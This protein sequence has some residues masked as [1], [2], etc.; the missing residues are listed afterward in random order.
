MKKIYTLVLLAGMMLQSCSDFLDRTPSTSLPVEMAITNLK[1]LN[2]AVNGIPYILIGKRMSYDSDF[3]IFADMRGEDFSPKNNVNQSGNLARYQ[4]TKYDLESILLYGNFYQAIANVNKIFSVIDHVPYA[5]QEAAKFNDLKGQLYA[6]RALLHFDLARSFSQAP[7]VCSDIEAPNSGIVL[8][9]GVYD[10]HYIGTRATL[11][12]TYDQI[13]EDFTTA[14]PLLSK[15]AHNGYINYWAALALRSRAYLYYGKDAEALKDAKDVIASDLYKLYDIDNYISVW[16][17]EYTSESLFELSVTTIYNS[18]RNAL[19][20]YCDSEGYGEC[21]FVESAPLYAYL[22]SHPK[23]IRSKLIKIQEGQNPSTGKDYQNPGKFPAKYPGREGS[24]YINNPK[25][26]RLSEVYL[27][28]AEA[29]LKSRQG[30]PEDYINE[31]REKRIE[32]YEPVSSV[33]LDDI[34]SE[35]RYELFTE[36][37]LS[38]DMWRNKKSIKNSN[39]GVVDYNDYRTIFPL[40]QDEIDVSHG[41]LVQNP[42]Y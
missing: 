33:T 1:D 30:K 25:I 24:L 16:G 27:I 23:D 4:A 13:I 36:N 2:N 29:S 34:L 9:L 21:M 15:E 35:R 6:W 26:I 7:T 38:F 42:K 14:L 12:E 10:S 11:K 3:G 32:G 17:Q 22:S 40:P 20:Y 28:A 5:E 19:G 31:L 39:V 8:S 41:K 18:Q 37:H